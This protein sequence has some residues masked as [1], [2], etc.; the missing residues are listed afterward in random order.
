MTRHR[1]RGPALGAALLC[2]IMAAP[3][4]AAPAPASPAPPAKKKAATT[5]PARSSRDVTLNEIVVTGTQDDQ[6]PSVS[7]VD[8]RTLERHGGESV[9]EA[10]ER[11][12]SVYTTSGRG[13]KRTF[14]LRG[15]D[16][17]QVAVLLDGAPAYIPYDG[18]LDLEMIPVDAVDHVT[19]VK[20]P[21]SVRYGPGGMGGAVNIVTRT[22]GKGPLAGLLAETGLG[23]ALRLSAVHAMTLGPVGYTV[24]GGWRRR[25]AFPL[26]GA[27]AADP[28]ENGVLRENSDRSFFHVGANVRARLPGGHVIRAGALLVDGEKGIPPGLL[29]PVVRYW[30]FTLW[31]AVGVTL[32]HAGSYLGGGLKVDE[33]A[34]VRLF[35]N[36]IDSY[37]DASYTTQTSAR[38]FSSLY[39]DRMAG[40]RARARLRLENA[41]WGP[42][43]LRLWVGGQY[44]RHEKV[45]AQDAAGPVTR[46]LLTLTPEAEAFLGGRRSVTAAFQ[47][48]LEV[49][50]STP[51]GDA[52]SRLGLGPLISAR[53]D[54]WDALTLQA[55]VARR[56]RFPTLKERFTRVGGARVPNP[57]LAPES[58]WHVGLDATWR[59]PRGL[60][61]RVALHDAE[62]TDLINLTALG[63]G[64][65]QLRNVPGVRLLGADIQVQ[66]APTP[67]LRL[68]VAYAFLHARR[69]QERAGSDLLPYRPA[70]QALLGVR[71]MPVSRVDLETVVR[72]VSQ[73]PYQDPASA[74]WGELAVRA[75][76]DARLSVRLP[77]R[78]VLHGQVC[79][80]LDT[81]TQSVAGY[82]EPGREVWVGLRA[83]YGGP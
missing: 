18:V 23:N 57:D 60:V 69:V 22:A 54:P 51:S 55:T 4:R 13:G 43:D 20:G 63:G 19:L 82:P 75:T 72:V 62:V 24:F 45:P 16:Q 74:R 48:D 9:V 61:A 52:A 6:G 59:G 27:F 47:V 34:F 41:P 67:W 53:F 7:R 38:A 83:R 73:R 1:S 17:R 77:G 29:E 35:D 81:A 58:A 28:R 46:G 64:K 15:F 44:D 8:R 65:E 2:L 39:R 25:D 80:I 37:D 56:G 68:R 14:S 50:G 30:R 31:R 11:D 66:A 71:L 3:A 5:P 78:V 49:P 36:R 21:S 70:H 12:P 76:W 32:G 26:S 42:T 10:L 79:N 40:G 33:L